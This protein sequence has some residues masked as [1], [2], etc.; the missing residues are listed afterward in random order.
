MNNLEIY[1][2]ENLIEY[3]KGFSEI[4]VASVCRDLGISKSNISSGKA[5]I[6]SYLKIIKELQERVEKINDKTGIL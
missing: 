3:I 2:K 1:K 6:D 4:T 5:G